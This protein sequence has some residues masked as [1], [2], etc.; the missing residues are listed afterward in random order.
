MVFAGCFQGSWWKDYKKE[1][2]EPNRLSVCGLK[3]ARYQINN[4]PHAYMASPERDIKPY[5]MTSTLLT[6]GA[7]KLSRFH[8]KDKS[9]YTFI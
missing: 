7:L 8:S 4:T 6:P 1:S 9:N 3:T 5:N 2:V